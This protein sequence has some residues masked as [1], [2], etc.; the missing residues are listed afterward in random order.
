MSEKLTLELMR[1][2]AWAHPNPKLFDRW[3]ETEEGSLCPYN[4]TIS[5]MHFFREKRELW[6]PG[7]PQMR[8]YDLIIAIMKEKN[9]IWK[10]K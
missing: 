9:W 3:A 2:D 7:P 1:R 5:R 4:H 10:N 8:D 6:Q